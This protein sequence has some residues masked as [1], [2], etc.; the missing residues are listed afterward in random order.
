MP[1]LIDGPQG[2]IAADSLAF[3]NEGELEK[4]VASQPNLLETDDEEPLA[5][6]NSQV[7]L[8]EAG[9][10]DLLFVSEAGLPVAVEVKLARNGESRREVVAQVVD[11][12][13]ALT[14]LTVDELNQRVGG[15][16]EIALRS[17]D[18]GSDIDEFDRPWQAVGANLRAGL[19]RVVLVLDDV[20]P[21][22]ERIVRFLSDHSNLDVRL[23]TISKYAAQKVGILYVPRIIITAQG[24]PAP[25]PTSGPRP[26]RPEL[27]QVI[28][29]YDQMAA[30]ELQTRG[31]TSWYRQIR[32][33]EWPAGLRVHYEFV[34]LHKGIGA[35]LHL[36]NDRATSLTSLLSQMAGRKV[37][38]TQS[39]LQWDPKWS[40]GK[41]RLMVRYPRTEPPDTIAK[42]MLD[43]IQLTREPVARQVSELGITAPVNVLEDGTSLGDHS[44]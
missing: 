34:Y 16:L 10:L 32:P 6:V 36:E 11:Y 12:V 29:A 4:V 3:D 15:S 20:R 13:S 18:A 14:S 40:R 24:K 35:E 30:S 22:L 2:R 28:Q 21:D 41:G 43:L 8:P 26:L 1:I 27:A 5:L 7:T 38:P 17:F 25:R 31:N 39:E 44:P 33:P 42:S 9:S 37:G 19:A 23:V